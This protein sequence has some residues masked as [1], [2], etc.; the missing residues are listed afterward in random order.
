[1]YNYSESTFDLVRTAILPA[2][3]ANI[4]PGMSNYHATLMAQFPLNKTVSIYDRTWKTEVARLN[5]HEK[6]ADGYPIW[7]GNDHYVVTGGRDKK[8]IVWSAKTFLEVYRTEATIELH[9]FRISCDSKYIFFSGN[10][11]AEL[12]KVNNPELFGNC[13]SIN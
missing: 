5:G 1:M 9:N 3:S 7:T 13:N 12:W 10:Q 6:Q 8:I 2:N 4:Q 11:S